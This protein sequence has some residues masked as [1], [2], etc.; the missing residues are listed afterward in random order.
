M[1][2]YWLGYYFKVLQNATIGGNCTIK[3]FSVLFLTIACETTIFSIKISIK[4]WVRESLPQPPRAI[5]AHTQK[6]NVFLY[7]WNVNRFSGREF[8][9]HLCIEME[10]VTVILFSLAL[11]APHPPQWMRALARGVLPAEGGCRKRASKCFW[12]KEWCNVFRAMSQKEQ[13]WGNWVK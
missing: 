12:A 4:K 3:D 11:T 8:F 6:V 10:E 9:C 5:P 2:I 1:S 13:P 7:F